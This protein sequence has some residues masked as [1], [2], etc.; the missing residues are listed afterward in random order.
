MKLYSAPNPAP[1]PRR[2]LICLAEKGVEIQITDLSLMKGQHKEPDFVAKNSRAQVPVLELDDGRTISESIA[3]CRYLDELYPN[4]PLFGRD[5]FERAEIDMWVRRVEFNL[6]TPV[7]NFWVHAHP[8]TA[9][10]GTQ[11]KDFGEGNRD[12]WESAARWFDGELSCREFICGT[13]FTIADIAALTTVDFAT[14]IGLKIPKSCT[15]LLLWQTRV[16]NR[17]SVKSLNTMVI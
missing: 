6:M 5:A 7:G 12:R 3:I 10:L 11:H 8:Y 13:E 15:H 4:P 2:V 1:N 14:W 9:R 16:S 17:P